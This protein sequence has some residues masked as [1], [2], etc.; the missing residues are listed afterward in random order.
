MKLENGKITFLIDRD[1]A[2]IEIE[3]G[4]SNTM[5]AKIILTPEQLCQAMSR[6]AFTPCSLEVKG[7]DRVGKKHENKDHVFE[8]P[9]EIFRNKENAL[10]LFQLAKKTTPEGWI[11]DNY[12][13]SQNSFFSKDGKNYARCVIRRWI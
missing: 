1:G 8:L 13:S 5:F 7:L 3:D 11:P 12:F 9:S 4:N 10:A 2:T 6:Q